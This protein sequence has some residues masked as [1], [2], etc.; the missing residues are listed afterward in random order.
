MVA[1]LQAGKDG[2]AVSKTESLF[3]IEDPNMIRMG[4]IFDV[5]HDGKQFLVFRDAEDQPTS[6]ITLIT[7]WTA[8]LPK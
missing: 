5:S 2:W 4:G 7:N 8:A 3:K 1:T 6:N